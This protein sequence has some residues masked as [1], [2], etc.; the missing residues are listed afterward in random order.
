MAQMKISNIYT[1]TY[2]HAQVYTHAHAHAYTHKVG[3]W[4]R[5]HW[6]FGVMSTI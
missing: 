6:E 3:L 4:M 1:H 2:A 5:D